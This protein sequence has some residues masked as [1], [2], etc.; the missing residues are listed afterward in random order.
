MK[1]TV[2]SIFL[3]LTNINYLSAQN[4]YENSRIEFEQAESVFSKIYLDN[5]DESNSH[6]KR[7]YAEALPTF[8]KL[9]KKDPA[10]MNLAFKIG[11]CYQSTRTQRSKAISYFAKAVTSV[12]DN[13][14]GSSFKEKNAPVIAYKFLGDAYHLNY[15]FDKA[16]L[17]YEKYISVMAENKHTEKKQLLE[18][19]RKIEMCK[20]AKVLV[21][22]PIA[23]KLQNLGTTVNSSSGDYSPVLSADQ[24]TLYFTSR[25]QESTGN[26][27]DADGN[28]MEDIYM[29][30]QT[31]TGWSIAKNIGA[32][33]NTEW[34]EAT[35]GL[36]PD[37]QTILIYRDDMGD[38]N[39][40]TTRLDGDVWET[41][42]K[43][44]DNINSRYWEPSAFISA[45][46][47]KIYFTSD[48][49]GGYGGRDLY[50]S[51]RKFF[52]DWEP[53]I[54]MGPTINTAFD[55]DAPFIHPDGITLYFS[56][57]GHNTMGGFD[58]FSSLLLNGETWSAPINVG[59]PINTTDDDVFYVISP[60]SKTAYFSS[61]REGGV[62]EKDNFMAT[63]PNHKET[64]LTLVKGVVVDETGKPVKQVKIT[65]TDNET[66]EIVG[67][68]DANSK[69]GQFLF[70]L[71]PNKNYN[72]TYQAQE[73]LFYSE[74]LEI[75]KE[76]NYYELKKAVILNP[77]VVG[78]KI[79]L[80][81]IFFD[82]DKASLRPLSNVEIKN[83]VL[84][85]K[86]NPNLKVE[87]SA[88]TD[89]KGNDEYN[90]NLSEERARA[91]VNKLIENGISADRFKAKG[92]G[93]NKPAAA[94][95]KMD[96]ADNPQG[97]QLNRRVEF[98]ITEIN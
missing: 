47:S 7:G 54:N 38:G 70:I 44:N 57:N 40:Y 80:N 97:R 33:I 66:E 74:N 53:A 14:S 79:V 88:Y 34:H 23:V 29:S 67:V 91:V 60:D 35:V 55:E 2:I 93:E 77:I 4:T 30:T 6:S 22:N 75:P 45:D 25:R 82:F 62:G 27:K 3:L 10:N 95:T 48:K 32:P 15:Q 61:F 96:G 36:S 65:I 5:K 56:S 19:G 28:F 64:P 94:N 12:S 85:M 63:F 39:I 41:P 1:T 84:L 86:S 16:I 50:V 87:I 52:G 81:N 68:Y 11:V 17:A 98:T 58:I 43:L 49:P 42:I 90:Q 20:V 59:F 83:L 9:Y 92:Y 24:Q 8:S 78:S 37:G 21:A 71:T 76:T 26:E 18:A 51:R 73:H 89:S 69:T 72:I 13:Y 46:G 31:K